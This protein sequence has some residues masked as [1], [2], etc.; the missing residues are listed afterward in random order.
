MRY[1]FAALITIL[2]AGAFAQ[3]ADSAAAAG[4]PPQSTMMSLALPALVL[5]VFYVTLIRPQQRRMKEH[6]ATLGALKKGD[7]VVTG[8]GIVGK[9]TKIDTGSDTMSVEIA[10]GVEVNVLKS[11]VTGLVTVPKPVVTEKKADKKKAAGDKNDNSVPSRNSVAN[12][13]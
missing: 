5:I 6:Q 10:K 12:D 7:E 8:G 9:I 13:N 11:T 1:L 4:V 3:A 2:P